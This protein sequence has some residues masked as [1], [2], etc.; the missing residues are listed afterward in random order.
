M[1]LEPLSASIICNAGPNGIPIPRRWASVNR[2]RFPSS[3]SSFRKISAYSIRSRL[4]GTKY[5]MEG[6]GAWYLFGWPAIEG[7]AAARSAHAAFAIM[8]AARELKLP[9]PAAW[10]LQFG[11]TIASDLMVIM[12]T[13]HEGEVEVAGK[14]INLA[15]RLKR[16]DRQAHRARPHS[17]LSRGTRPLR[18]RQAGSSRQ[19]IE[20]G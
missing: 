2:C 4:G 16:G 10:V 12:P 8:Q 20:R 17:L 5:Q 18:P 9:V 1:G 11:V 19:F 15:A 3:I 7:N 14:A 6:D 13:K